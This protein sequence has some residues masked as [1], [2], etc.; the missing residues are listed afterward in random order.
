MRLTQ[1][2]FTID[3]FQRLQ[4]KMVA[5]HDEITKTMNEVNSF[6]LNAIIGPTHRV[7]NAI[8]Q[9]KD[10]IIYSLNVIWKILCLTIVRFWY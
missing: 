10:S 7:K 1:P 5:L 2:K 9:H 8:N 3:I 4:K 6:Q